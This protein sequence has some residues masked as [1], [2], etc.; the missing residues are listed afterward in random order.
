[1]SKIQPLFTESNQ[2]NKLLESW[3]HDH[4]QTPK[5]TTVLTP[6]C[7]M[8]ISIIV[9]YVMFQQNIS[10]AALMVFSFIVYSLILNGLE[11]Y[12]F[13]IKKPKI[14]WNQSLS[15]TD[16]NDILCQYQEKKPVLDISDKYI[17]LSYP[18]FKREIIWSSDLSWQRYDTGLVILSHLHI[19]T[20]HELMITTDH[21]HFKWIEQKCLEHIGKPQTANIHALT[22]HPVNSDLPKGKTRDMNIDII[23]YEK[24]RSHWIQYNTLN[25]Y[26]LILLAC[27]T[28]LLSI[29]FSHFNNIFTYSMLFVFQVINF[30]SLDPS[31]AIGL[32]ITI[33][34][35][36]TLLLIIRYMAKKSLRLWC[37]I[38]RH[39]IE[40]FD[41]RKRNRIMMCVLCLIVPIQPFMM[42][43]TSLQIDLFYLLWA[44]IGLIKTLQL[45]ALKPSLNIENAM[46]CFN[47]FGFTNV[48]Q[49]QNT[50]Q[51]WYMSWEDMAALIGFTD[52][53]QSS[54]PHIITPLTNHTCMIT[55]QQNHMVVYQWCPLNIHEL[56]K[57]LL[58]SYTPV[59]PVANPNITTLS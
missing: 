58:G 59:L 2:K 8:L 55:Y 33:S 52:H 45:W 36:I 26:G 29:T 12:Q 56:K 11:L 35:I 13:L 31:A 14:S 28:D 21:P 53:D 54:E 57:Y 50:K 10:F 51:S 9:V 32:L 6:Y 27:Y 22:F 41:V 38:K 16:C 19:F 5:R 3:Y 30:F 15:L 1:M 43:M 18:G 49:L 40:P 37:I 25:L 42:V 23:E 48:F 44:L 17:S 20:R 24:D 46:F 47:E 4:K 7:L 39:T 34:V